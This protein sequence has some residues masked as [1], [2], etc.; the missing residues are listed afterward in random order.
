[1][2]YKNKLLL[3]LF[4]LSALFVIFNPVIALF[5]A[6]FTACFA[7]FAIGHSVQDPSEIFNPLYL[8][9]VGRAYRGKIRIWP[10]QDCLVIDYAGSIDRCH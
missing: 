8:Q 2:S 1:M 7:V 6:L 9:Q 4:V 10:K 5:G 3:A